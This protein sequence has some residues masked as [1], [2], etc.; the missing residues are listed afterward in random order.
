[1]WLSFDMCSLYAWSKTIKHGYLL[2]EMTAGQHGFR[3]T[4]R[5]N[6][7]LSSSRMWQQT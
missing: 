3:G 6:R 4:G 1:M 5:C 7:K 2:G